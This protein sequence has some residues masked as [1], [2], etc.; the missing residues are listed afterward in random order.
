MK[1]GIR[2][3]FVD[4]SIQSSSLLIS[5]HFSKK[6]LNLLSFK[7]QWWLKRGQGAAQNCGNYK[8]FGATLF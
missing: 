6:M 1:P 3:I 4:E 7:R 5:D 8:W 2:K